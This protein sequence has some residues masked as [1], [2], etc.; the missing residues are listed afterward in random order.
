VKRADAENGKKTGDRSDVGL[1][2]P[3][4]GDLA[5]QFPDLGSNDQSVPHS[6]FLFVGSVPQGREER[7]LEV[8]RGVLA[9]L[10]GPVRAQLASDIEYFVHPAK[11]RRVAVLPVRFSHD[12][13]AIRWKLRDALVDD[14]FDVDDSFPLIY[15][16]HVTLEYL[17]DL[18]ET[19]VG[20]VPSGGW[21]LNGIE[22]WGLPRVVEV[23]F[24]SVSKLAHRHVESKAHHRSVALMKF[25]SGVARKLG[26]GNDV[27]VVGGA[28][29]NFVLDPTGLKY[30]IK[31]IDV[32]IDPVALRRPDASD[33][34][35]QKVKRA[36][37]VDVSLV[38]NSYGVSIVTI[39]GDWIL[40][41][42]SM[43]GEVIEI[44]NARTESYGGTAGKGYKPHLVE[45]ATIE[46]DVKRRDFSFNT[47]LWRMHDLANG[48]D[49][50]AILDL[51]G[52]GMKDLQD[53][54]MRCPSKPDRTFSDDPSRMVRTIKFMLKYGFKIS[55][56]VKASIKKNA[57]KL[58][59][60]P[61]GHLS[62][63]I[64][65]TFF[66]PGVGKKALLEMD[67]L[68]LLEVTRDI[69]RK[70]KKFR[71]ALANWADAH[72]SVEFI[73]DLMD[74]G[75]PSGKRLGFLK[76]AQKD[77]VREITVQMDAD[78]SD[79]FVRLLEQP[80]K[81][82]DMPGLITE[83]G[84][85]GAEIRALVEA[86]RTALLDEP[87]LASSGRKWE[88]KI[89]RR[90][91]KP[92]GKT[93]GN[94]AHVVASKPVVID[95]VHLK[96]LKKDFLTFTRQIKKPKDYDQ[97]RYMADAYT[98]WR[99]QF[100]DFI[101]RLWKY[102]DGLHWRHPNLFSEND[103]DYWRRV[104]GEDT[105]VLQ[106]ENFPLQHPDDYWTEEQCVAEFE[107]RRG[108]WVRKVQRGA[109]EAWSRLDD[110]VSWMETNRL[111]ALQTEGDKVTLEYPE[112]YKENIDGFQLTFKGIEPDD[113]AEVKGFL[114]GLKRYKALAAKRM[115]LLLRRK[116][117]IVVNSMGEVGLEWGGQYHT[118]YIDFNLASSSSSGIQNRTVHVLAHEMGHH[119]FKSLG[120]K[121]RKFW[122]TLIRG[123]MEPLDL[124]K[125][126]PLMKAGE[127][128]QW[129]A[130]DIEEKDPI[131]A[132]Q[133][134]GVSE[135]WR[136]K[137]NVP[138]KEK[139]KEFIDGGEVQIHVPKRPITY[140]ASKNPEEAFCEVVGLL[141]ANGPGS[142]DNEILH[143]L[144]VIV[145]SAKIAN[146][147][148][149]VE[150]PKNTH[151]VKVEPPKAKR[152]Q[153]PFVGYID[154]QGIKIDVENKQ[155]D[156]RKGVSPDGEEWETHMFHHY[157][158]IRNTEGTDGDKLDVYVGDNHDSSLAVVVHQQDPD[159]GKFDEDKVMLGFDSVEE[160]IGA[161]KKQY[162]QPGF[163]VE[164]EHLEMPIGQF[165]RWVN[166]D[167][168]KG[169]KVKDAV[170]HTA[171]QHAPST[172]P[173]W[174]PE[175]EGRVTDIAASGDNDEGWK[176]ASQ[177]RTA[178]H[179]DDYQRREK[180][181]PEDLDFARKHHLP[182]EEDQYWGTVV[183]LKALYTKRPQ[184][185][186][187]GMNLGDQKRF[188]FASI[189]LSLLVPA[190]ETVSLIGLHR[191]TEG[192]VRSDKG[193]PEVVLCE[194]AFF[195]MEGHTRLAAERLRGH[196]RAEVKL[197]LYDGK[198]FRKPTD[199]DLPSS[200]RLLKRRRRATAAQRIADRY[201]EGLQ[202]NLNVGDPVFYGKWK[203]S[204]G[205]IKDFKTDPK[206]GDP[207]VTVEPYP[208]G[209]KKPKD[210]K[211]LKIRERQPKPEEKKAGMLEPPPAMVKSVLEWVMAV[212][213]S[214]KAFRA[215]E[216]LAKAQDV[217]QALTA[218]K[219]DMTKQ[220]GVLE[221]AVADPKVGVRAEYA[222]LKQ[223]V[224][225]LFED[226]RR[227][228]VFVQRLVWGPPKFKK[229]TEAHNKGDLP[230]YVRSVGDEVD[231][232]LADRMKAVKGQVQKLRAGAGGPSKVQPIMPGKELV[233]R[234]PVDLRGWKY[235]GQVTVEKG[236]KGLVDVITKA[237]ARKTDIDEESRK[238]FDELMEGNKKQWQSIAVK[239]DPNQTPHGRWQS[240]TKM[241]TLKF[242]GPEKDAAWYRPL[243]EHE[244]RHVAQDLINFSEG[245][246]DRGGR[247]SRKMLT[248]DYTQQDEDAARQKLRAVGIDP[249]QVA[250]HH[251]DDV[252][253]YTDLADAVGEY[254]RQQPKFD[255]L[256]RNETIR[257]FVGGKAN[258]EVA[259]EL[260]SL[261]M[262][263]LPFFTTLKR[264]PSA[265][266]KYQKAV[267]ELLKAT[268]G[269]ATRVALR[270]LQG[271]QAG[272][273]Q[274]PPAL[275]KTIQ[276]WALATY[277]GHILAGVETD[278]ET[279][280]D[281]KGPI[282]RAIQDMGKGYD[283]VT[284]AGSLSV[285]GSFKF[286]M[287]DTF[288][289]S[290]SL[291]KSVWGVKRTGEDVYLIGK[292]DRSVSW[293]PQQ[294]PWQWG[295]GPWTLEEV[296]KHLMPYISRAT[297]RMRSKLDQPVV[298][299]NMPKAVELTL[300]K[301]KCLQ[302]TT[303][304]KH[305]SG[306]A[307]TKF[308][309]DL[310]GWKYLPNPR[311]AEKHIKDEEGW[312]VVKV[313]LDF[314]GSQTKGGYWSLKERTLDVEIGAGATSHYIRTPE[315]A[316]TVSLFE[317]GITQ[318]TGTCRHEVQHIGQDA[319]RLA[320]GLSEDA[321]L[322]GRTLRNPDFTPEGR[323]LHVP[324]G[325]APSGKVHPLRDVEFHTR[326]QDEIEKFSR[327][328]RKGVVAK[329]K[330][331]EALHIWVGASPENEMKDP[332]GKVIMTTQQFF[333]SLRKYEKGKWQ[334]AVDEF[335]KGLMRK[336]LRI[337]SEDIQSAMTQRVR[338]DQ[339][340]FA[341]LLGTVAQIQSEIDA[342]PD[343]YSTSDKNRKLWLAWKDLALLGDR[344]ARAVLDQ[345]SI[346]PG[347][348]KAFELAARAFI[349]IR[350]TPR[351]I[352][353][354]MVKNKR[355]INLL[356][357]TV[358]WPDKSE[359]EKLKVGA[360]T[361]H[362]TL[363]LE[364]ADLDRSKK[365]VQK[366]ESLI[367]RMPFPKGLKQVLYGDVYIVARLNKTKTWAFYYPRDDNVYVRADTKGVLGET[368]SLIHELAH[369]YWEQFASVSKKHAWI[370]HH[371]H[372]SGKSMPAEKM[373]MPNVGE[374]L[375]L[376][377]P[378]APRGFE[379][380]VSHVHA[381]KYWFD[382]PSKDGK[383]TRTMNYPVH[384]MAKFLYD[385]D[386]RTKR[387]ETF[388]T[389]YAAKNAEEHFCESTALRALGKLKG[390]NL[391]EYDRIWGGS[392]GRVASQDSSVEAKVDF[393]GT[394]WVVA[395]PSK[396]DE[397]QAET[398]WQV[399]HTSY[400]NL[401]EHIS[402]LSE[403]LSK[404]Q[405]FWLVDVDGDEKPDAF[406]AY[407]KTPAGKKIGVI[408]SDGSPLAKRLVVRKLLQLFQGNG[409]YV[410][411]SGRPAQMLDSAGV[412]HVT[413]QADVEA[414]MAPK[415]IHWLGDG[416]Y[417]R[418][419]GGLGTK[420]KRLYGHPRIPRARKQARRLATRWLRS[421]ASIPAQ[422]IAARYLEAGAYPTSRLV[423]GPLIDGHIPPRTPQGRPPAYL[424]RSMPVAE[425]EAAVSR[426]QMRGRPLHAAGEPVFYT[427]NPGENV[428]VAIEYRD[429][430]GWDSKVG[431][432]GST[433]YAI[434]HD[435]IP[436][437]RVAELARGAKGDLK[438][439][440]SAAKFKDKKKVK[441][442]DGG[443][444]TGGK[445]DVF[446]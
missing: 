442:Q 317:T 192:N 207:V 262:H 122:D 165:W 146:L 252:E 209:R 405:L 258:P 367:R 74:L 275:L 67:K 290:S 222:A 392:G 261:R 86:A 20:T 113:R 332:D 81:V 302:Y 147:Q 254:K 409:Y 80:G 445:A 92:A 204:P 313:V 381:G 79:A 373:P 56:E 295:R 277:A 53:G 333:Y 374:T 7:L 35:A 28:V 322:P 428:L 368:H 31:D 365:N 253:F 218:L 236:V 108:P 249:R 276:E 383:T 270:Y 353:K 379:P 351:D 149:V 162:D 432:G 224:E 140:Y 421:S 423:E 286:P 371:A 75:M 195:V 194:S 299:P 127:D 413:D 412:P 137:H 308:K 14:G 175:V 241:L 246:Y 420:E 189:P 169:K 398:V 265:R 291:S 154:F 216:D 156:V 38:T 440:K 124:K 155:G 17:N 89:R 164:G 240:A 27:Y 414:V 110:F 395:P 354:W 12:L 343:Y 139:V 55:S 181:L 350:G 417:T 200:V 310:S 327:F 203:S 97:A 285:G 345:K 132:L 402:N 220:R 415:K 2:I 335:R 394:R 232:A 123:D 125:I 172:A 13:A 321:G 401:G 101:K 361:V 215:K 130:F 22:V 248:P 10:S 43:A 183:P 19:Y 320:K 227:T 52:C 358:D 435:A 115:P 176:A 338:Q 418:A 202:I 342:H 228:A 370:R 11:Q 259:Q 117:P 243:I 41:G 337:S 4:P 98:R 211:L 126:Y 416:K 356:N 235:E 284:K 303:K 298:D 293:K 16:P 190:Q 314:K 196:S 341:S 438:R 76:P 304:A 397:A 429:R 9:E 1:F 84:F 65:E 400:G 70:D 25:L 426:G 182:L 135:D 372:M 301:R 267:N 268:G 305:Y 46:E 59:N 90:L 221:D 151:P 23:P 96:K 226:N 109:R 264:V 77:R 54:W 378:G 160:A 250:I 152:K 380:V 364:G 340:Y 6:T 247:P 49:Q 210:L 214:T 26:V 294:L 300:L 171:A 15:R 72:A 69:A 319:L 347:K 68:G 352:E 348:N 339:E 205:T 257:F 102:M 385:R 88:D 161:Y 159:S 369:R 391:D 141:V 94:E 178:E 121:S 307:T 334:K 24:S 93:A 136:W 443:E 245:L 256:P 439:W 230:R 424:Y 73:F 377:I 37:P 100:E 260:R 387:R 33:W 153:F 193:V 61:P 85:K 99:V 323:K 233:T 111:Q 106:T 396:L 427:L 191:Y 39:T 328:V 389:P 376:K 274:G 71:Q 225:T 42:V 138:T 325:D 158:E 145:P 366:A 229:F 311:E 388:P 407:K 120:S 441:K 129:L 411:A 188:V 244:L 58:K 18:D 95:E 408:G 393:S 278:L 242:G 197:F 87:L 430:D 36:I 8:V 148:G 51:T 187:F 384:E 331:K 47:L 271:K 238:F 419:I 316:R 212:T 312:D 217:L 114:A 32:V 91:G 326:I 289:G 281:A 103:R 29:R 263:P 237:M 3:L 386:E 150:V 404:Y 144:R 436:M 119:I 283:E 30:P 329:A 62:N 131:L 40:D 272:V 336:G 318:I 180:V 166:E 297:Q 288:G 60:I 34:F 219:R 382:V 78:G 363:G 410:E 324:E 170:V 57:P 206:S 44:A 360:F 48:P 375:P 359:D 177:R 239:L 116:L 434:T 266:G 362:N 201:V 173:T 437:S 231:E 157:G 280:L 50:V 105:W 168:N 269:S 112:V 133:L 282:K 63:M 422:Q 406:I 309:L 330:I 273:F 255:H 185:H 118:R 287:T 446:F 399:Y 223:Y 315:Q 45:P 143:W 163:Y 251:L 64:I 179:N 306:K 433:I 83:Y 21:S 82:L 142:V 208:K 390:S 199:E 279:I 213:Q 5:S 403:L 346:P 184:Y 425:Y 186:I 66:T 198:K 444:M 355:H 174:F 167:R 107:Q 349:S 128:L 234:I 296:K 357:D 104:V 134:T 431:M 292:G 344:L